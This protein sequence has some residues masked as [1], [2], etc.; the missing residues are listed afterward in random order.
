MC[1]NFFYYEKPTW[2][3]FLMVKG[4]HNALIA[5]QSPCDSSYIIAF[6]L[7]SIS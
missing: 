5:S 2:L 7:E 1:E 3:I 4:A 6:S